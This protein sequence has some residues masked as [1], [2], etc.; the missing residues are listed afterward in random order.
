[1]IIEKFE[2]VKSLVGGSI[3]QLGYEAGTFIYHDDKT[4]NT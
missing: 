3:S 1:M 4:H 2:A